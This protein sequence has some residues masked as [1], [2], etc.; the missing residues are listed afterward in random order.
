MGARVSV[1]IRSLPRPC[2]GSGFRPFEFPISYYSRSHA[3]GK[4]INWR[5]A[6][7]C[8][9]ILLKVRMRRR[10]RLFAQECDPAA[11]NA[12][13]SERSIYS[14]YAPRFAIN[15]QPGDEKNVP[16]VS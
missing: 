13:N 3:D 1:W 5:D 4:K 6:F 16:A 2:F 11:L 12:L 14:E 9:A 8:V 7:A 15:S 10:K